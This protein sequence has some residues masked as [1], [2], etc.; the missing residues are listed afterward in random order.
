MG[1][2]HY[3][4]SGPHK[5][6]SNRRKLSDE[7]RSQTAQF[8]L[9][10]ERVVA[11][12]YRLDRTD[13]VLQSLKNH[14]LRDLPP[15]RSIPVSPY[16]PIHGASTGGAK[17]PARSAVTPVRLLH[18]RNPEK[19]LSQAT[20]EE[21]AVLEACLP[22]L[23]HLREEQRQ[24]QRRSGIAY[25]RKEERMKQR[26]LM[27]KLYPKAMATQGEAHRVQVMG[28]FYNEACQVHRQASSASDKATAIYRRAQGLPP[29][30]PR[31]ANRRRYQL[32]PGRKRFRRWW[33]RVRFRKRAS[34]LR[35][36]PRSPPRWR[37]LCPGGLVYMHVAGAYAHGRV[38]AFTLNLDHG[39]EENARSQRLPAAWLRERIVRRA[40][41]V[42]GR[43]VEVLVC[44]ELHESGRLHAHG[45]MAGVSL[46]EEGDLQEALKLAGGKDYGA[47]QVR[48]NMNRPDSGWASYM[49]KDFDQPFE[50]TRFAATSGLR[51]SAENV[52]GKLR[53]F[54][55][56]H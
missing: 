31:D 52:F 40:E 18:A 24:A 21:E 51:A 34:D 8:L 5:E 10:L 19:L 15:C 9:F 30:R 6:L 53:K 43:R 45:V 46:G 16:R 32:R 49:A 44:L 29:V 2:H 56:E 39:V 50:W 26:R 47:R 37:D 1:A 4:S 7:Q 3:G 23:L 41:Q 14:F 28:E 13:M 38:I 11:W 42:L 22:E 55:V 20:L 36:G 27:M 54:V 35:R 48:I 33:E 12:G 17:T 25:A